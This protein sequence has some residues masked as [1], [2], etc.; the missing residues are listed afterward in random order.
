MDHDERAKSK[1][2]HE[3]GNHYARRIFGI[4]QGKLYETYQTTSSISEHRPEEKKNQ[5]HPYKAGVFFHSCVG[6]VCYRR[7]C[8]AAHLILKRRVVKP[9]TA[10]AAFRDT[11]L[12]SQARRLSATTI[13]A[14]S[15]VSSGRAVKSAADAARRARRAKANTSRD[16]RG[17][18]SDVAGVPSCNKARPKA[19]RRLPERRFRR[20]VRYGHRT[21]IS[22]ARPHNASA[23]HARTRRRHA[24]RRQGGLPQE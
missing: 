20:I 1:A 2:A 10:S 5:H 19:A 24:P 17:L 4:S 21:C 3:N 11:R 16:T 7:L 9:A 22:G 18:P 14:A 13:A 23:R 12:P 6:D 15:V 8:V